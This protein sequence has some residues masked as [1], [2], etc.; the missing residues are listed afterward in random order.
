[1]VLRGV[2]PDLLGRRDPGSFHPCGHV[3]EA[4]IGTLHFIFQSRILGMDGKSFSISI[5]MG[6]R[7]ENI[8]APGFRRGS[9]GF[10]EFF[11]NGIAKA[12]FLYGLDFV[13]FFRADEA[14]EM[15]PALND[16]FAQI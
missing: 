5:V 3:I 12:T 14:H 15:I 6:A 7:G 16:E 10:A 13:R 4:V 8:E 11:Q 2:V 9:C 1:M